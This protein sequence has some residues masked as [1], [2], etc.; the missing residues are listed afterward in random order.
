MKR[1]NWPVL[2]VPAMYAAIIA[3]LIVMHLTGV[4]F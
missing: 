2:V 4:T 3:G 1:I